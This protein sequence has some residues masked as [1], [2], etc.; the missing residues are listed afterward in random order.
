M[1][2]AGRV[3]CLAAAAVTALALA[4]LSAA[5]EPLPASAPGGGLV[6][7]DLAYAPADP[8][9][10]RGHLLDLYLPVTADP[11]REAGTRLLPAL[12]D[13][14]VAAGNGAPVVIWTGGSGW[15][16]DDGKDSAA[17]LAEYLT[18]HGYAVA[19]VSVRSSTQARFPAQVHD[20]KAAIRWLRAHARQ[21]RLD[22][23][24]I[25][26][27]G[28]SSGGWVATMAAVTGN[29]PDLEGDVGVSGP[30]STVRAAVDLFGPADL[31]TLNGQMPVGAC[32]ELEQ[33]Y[34]APRCH[35][36]PNAPS[37]RLV[38]CPIQEC[39]DEAARVSPIRY[40]DE[41]DPPLLILHGTDDRLVPHGQSQQLYAAAQAA[42]VRASFVSVA[43]AGHDV[44]AVLGLT[45]P[46][47]YGV[48]MTRDCREE[49]AAASDGPGMAIIDR[50]LAA[51]LG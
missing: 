7:R 36:D 44:T 9:G 22:P 51:T 21:Y 11:D 13:A 46:R 2:L 14:P 29:D 37:S 6:M 19:G 28:D 32:A 33:A 35:D 18:Q 10:S 31:L 48:S 3:L 8:P 27:M 23:E 34:G 20:I 5:D 16:A 25:A 26:V 50:F 45:T 38:G 47:K 39:P 15:L 1:G 42:C 40:L 30:P 12:A 4:D 24:R 43:G 41:D 49:T 17:P